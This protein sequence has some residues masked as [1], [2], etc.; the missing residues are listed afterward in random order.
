MT[1]LEPRQQTQ[2]GLERL[3]I[4]L[5]LIAGVDDRHDRPKVKTSRRGRIDRA[6][7]K[8]ISVGDKSPQ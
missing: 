8:K 4:R 2:V 5:W 1:D 3:E 7:L 6:L